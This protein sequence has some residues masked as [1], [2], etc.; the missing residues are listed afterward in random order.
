[1]EYIPETKVPV[2]NS[3]K[4]VGADIPL[5]ARIVSLADVYDALRHRRVYKDSWPLDYTLKEI[6][7]ESGHQFDPEIVEAFFQVIDRIE[8]INRDLS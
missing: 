4:L 8:A 2:G 7:K 6:S 5:A 3:Q 1:M